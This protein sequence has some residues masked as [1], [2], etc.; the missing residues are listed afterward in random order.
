MGPLAGTL[1]LK[2]PTPIEGSHRLRAMLTT[3]INLDTA[4]IKATNLQILMQTE[5]LPQTKDLLVKGGTL[6]MGQ[7][8]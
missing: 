7:R 5:T 1:N 4:P 2:V 6:D 8:T 3:T